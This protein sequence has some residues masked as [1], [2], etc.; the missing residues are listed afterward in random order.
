MCGR[1][2]RREVL[3]WSR[4]YEHFLC[5]VVRIVA[6][7]TAKRQSE[8]IVLHRTTHPRGVGIAL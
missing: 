1:A 8:N 4:S 3:S 5:G 2:F 7:P 6:A